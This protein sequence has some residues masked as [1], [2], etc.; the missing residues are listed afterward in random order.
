MAVSPDTLTIRCYGVGFGD[1]FLL[2]FQYPSATADRHVLIDFGSTQKPPKA[3]NNLLGAIAADIKKVVGTRL[4]VLVATHRH[5][6]HVS[7]F[8]TKANGKGTGDLIAGLQPQLV[9]QPWTERLDAPVASPGP[10]HALT[11]A[12]NDALRLSLTRMRQVAESTLRE[13]RHLPA[14][15]RQEISFI[16]EDG[17]SNLLAVKNLARMGK[18][19]RAAYVYY[20]KKVP[21]L[22][23]L[24]PSVTVDVLGPPTVSQK[25]D[26]ANQ[27][28]TNQDEYWHFTN[29]WGLQA[30]TSRLVDGEAPLFP[31]APV[32]EARRIP[33]ENRW[34]VRRLQSVRAEQLL[35]IVR[36]MDDALNNTS[37]ILLFKAGKKKFLFPGDAQWE[38]WEYALKKN[39][40]DLRD[41]DVYKVGHHGS[42]NATPRTLWNSFAKRSLDKTAAGRL[43]TVMSTRTDSKHGHVD[44]GTEVPR[45]KL[46]RALDDWSNLRTTQELEPSGGL[47]L[48][49][50]FDLR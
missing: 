48:K 4:H 50:D 42:L 8:A 18:R 45:S 29:F 6:D 23:T 11:A 21:A 19:T 39:L 44:N 38:N 24:L 37:V 2:T 14:A 10:G 5:T 41:V 7:G 26:V 27:K 47:V 16:G 9:I 32:H 28:A 17:L 13:A 35:R 31:G 40:D 43:T 12:A 20:G 34:F 49:L 15:A 25:A 46:V 22:K 36:A 1:C 30:D 33:V 3:Q